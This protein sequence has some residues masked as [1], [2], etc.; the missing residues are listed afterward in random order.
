MEFKM[1]NF[2]RICYCHEERNENR[3]ST[4]KG[5]MRITRNIEIKVF[6]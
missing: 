4:K 3:D 5:E 2:S 6:K 1:E